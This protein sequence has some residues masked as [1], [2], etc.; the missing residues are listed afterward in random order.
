MMTSPQTQFNS[1]LW[2]NSLTCVWSVIS[3]VLTQRH[4]STLTWFPPSERIASL[5][6]R[7][8]NLPNHRS[9][10][11]SF[12]ALSITTN[13]LLHNELARLH[14]AYRVDRNGSVDREFKFTI[15]IQSLIDYAEATRMC[16]NVQY[17]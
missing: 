11:R 5:R 16:T 17:N 13:I 3:R 12:T 4:H 15:I 9:M 2:Y 10:L 7:L 8:S 14:T 6:Y 1:S